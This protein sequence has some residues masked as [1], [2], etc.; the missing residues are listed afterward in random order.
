MYKDAYAILEEESPCDTCE[1]FMQCRYEPLACKDFLDYTNDGKLVRYDDE[2]NE[3]EGN[4]EPKRRYYK[5]LFPN[6]QITA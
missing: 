6:D 1:N 4:K 2:G 3:I 5:V